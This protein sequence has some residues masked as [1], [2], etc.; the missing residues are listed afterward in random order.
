MLVTLVHMSP[1][2]GTCPCCKHLQLHKQTWS[3]DW[4][5]IRLLRLKFGKLED[6]HS[7]FSNRRLVTCKRLMNSLSL[8]ALTYTLPIVFRVE[9]WGLVAVAVSNP[10]SM[11]KPF[12]SQPE[13]AHRGVGLELHVGVWKLCVPL[14][15]ITE[16]RRI[17]SQYYQ[18]IFYVLIWFRTS[19]Y[20]HSYHSR[21]TNSL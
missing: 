16:V 12:V 5:S 19:P 18:S 3:L 17:S 14:G 1:K 8:Q 21:W 10:E 6:C 2:L 13:A 7:K 9:P 15:W 20:M 4:T 11:T